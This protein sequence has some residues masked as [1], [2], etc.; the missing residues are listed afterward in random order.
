M[1]T[2]A[3]LPKMPMHA[4]LSP[5]MSRLFKTS[6]KWPSY[7]SRVQ[8][9]DSDLPIRKEVQE[10]KF[11][12]FKQSFDWFLKAL[13][14]D[15]DE[16]WVVLEAGHG[17]TGYARFYRQLFDDV[18]GIDLK[19]YS[20]FH[21]GV[22]S[23]VADLTEPLPL[24]DASV[25][26][27]VSHSVLEHVEDVPAVLA[28]LDRV[29]KP[30]GL[31]FIT[32][33]GLYFSAEGA[34]VRL[35][36]LKYKSWEHLDPESPYYMLESSPNAKNPMAGHLNQLRF[37]DFMHAFGTVPWDLMRVSR[38]YDPRPIPGYVDTDRFAEADLRTRGFKILACKTWPPA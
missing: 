14:G 24:P 23:I 22:T 19:D 2:T 37:A 34:H 36:D 13:G 4:T 25:D 5:V 20:L 32:V 31:A 11:A 15:P 27:V 1:G 21:P 10:D 17:T 7:H 9:Y 12:G 8:A 3:R 38:A 26:L 18:Y 30:R 6:S 35:P 33:Y 28:T 29:L 16:N